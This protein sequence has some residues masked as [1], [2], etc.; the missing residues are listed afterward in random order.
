[1]E[2]LPRKQKTNKKVLL[3]ALSTPHL[4]ALK[5]QDLVSGESKTSSPGFNYT[6]ATEKGE[7]QTKKLGFHTTW[8]EADDPKK[9]IMICKNHKAE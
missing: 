3:A 7:K 1:M 8:V 2:P 5:Y 6:L 9:W 4:V